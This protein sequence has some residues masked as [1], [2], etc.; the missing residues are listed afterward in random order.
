MATSKAFLMFPLI[1]GTIF[2]I[3]FSYKW[4]SRQKKISQTIPQ[5]QHERKMLIRKMCNE[6]K[7]LGVKST[8]D[9]ID[10]NLIVDDAHRIIYCF[11]PKVACTNWKRIMF[12]LRRG[13]PYPDPITI[14]QS[15]VHGH[16]KFKVLENV[17]I[18]EKRG[19]Q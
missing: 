17:E 13:K 7:K 19:L 4:D 9:G 11:I 6:N 16:N 1:L 3:T 14:D 12:I 5:Q 2:L 10:K 15:L 8:E 18:L